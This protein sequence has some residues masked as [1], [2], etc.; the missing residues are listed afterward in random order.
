M[1]WQTQWQLRHSVAQIQVQAGLMLGFSRTQT[2]RIYEWDAGPCEQFFIVSEY[3]GSLLCLQ[4]S[5]IRA[6]KH[7]KMFG[8]EIDD[9]VT[10]RTSAFASQLPIQSGKM[11]TDTRTGPPESFTARSMPQT[12]QPRVRDVM[13]LET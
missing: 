2:T 9:Y 10:A 3:S 5:A 4:I 6:A 7:A 1:L 13:R 11:V 8:Y 12:R